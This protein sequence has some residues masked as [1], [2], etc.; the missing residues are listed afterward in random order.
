MLLFGCSVQTVVSKGKAKFFDDYLKSYNDL[1]K[2]FA[3]AAENKKEEYTS[4]F[5]TVVVETKKNNN[6]N[7]N[8][9]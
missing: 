8:K 4:L 9:I 1:R 7:N 2:L 6:N 3:H 5:T